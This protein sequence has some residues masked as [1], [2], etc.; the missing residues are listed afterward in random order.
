MSYLGF[1]YPTS[2]HNDRIGGGRWSVNHSKKERDQ[3]S[4]NAPDERRRCPELGVLHEDTDIPFSVLGTARNA[5][6]V[7]E[8]AEG[9]IA[10]AAELSRSSRSI[11]TGT[12]R[13]TLNRVGF[14]TR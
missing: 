5:A 8:A 7:F 9:K 3:Q 10:D 4:D 11:G 14:S 2:E 12:A 1:V 13:A 6:L